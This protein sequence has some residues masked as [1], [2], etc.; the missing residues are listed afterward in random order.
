MREEGEVEGPVD[1]RKTIRVSSHMVR[2]GRKT[3]NLLA[4]QM[5]GQLASRSYGRPGGTVSL[6]KPRPTI[7]PSRLIGKV[8]MNAEEGTGLTPCSPPEAS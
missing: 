6:A 7:C 1:A 4:G 3:T 5:H 8:L 2:V